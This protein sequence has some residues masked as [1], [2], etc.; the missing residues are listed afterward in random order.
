MIGKTIKTLVRMTIRAMSLCQ[1]ISPRKFSSESFLQNRL[2]P[3]DMRMFSSEKQKL[4]P[5]SKYLTDTQLVFSVFETDQFL[6]PYFKYDL[7]SI[8]ASKEQKELIRQK[9]IVMLINKY[10][11]LGNISGITAVYIKEDKKEYL[12]INS[13]IRYSCVRHEIEKNLGIFTKINKCEEASENGRRKI[14]LYIGNINFYYNEFEKS[15]S[16]IMKHL[17]FKLA[18]PIYNGLERHKFDSVEDLGIDIYEAFDQ[19]CFKIISN[20]LQLSKLNSQEITKPL[21]DH[22]SKF[23]DMTSPLD[24]LEFIRNLLANGIEIFKGLSKCVEGTYED[25]RERDKAAIIERAYMRHKKMSKKTDKDI[26]FQKFKEIKCMPLPTQK[27]IESEILSLDEKNEAEYSRSIDFLKHTFNIPWDNEAPTIWDINYS[28][29]ILDSSHYGLV[30]TKQR[31]LEFI[32]K[33][34]RIDNKKGLIV[35]LVGPPGVGKTSIA[36]GIAK[37]LQRPEILITMAGQSDPQYIKGFK[38]VY[39]DSQ[40]GVFIKQ[41]EMAKVKNP[42]FIL[43]EIDKLGFD[44]LKGYAN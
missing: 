15:V 17:P 39:V 22:L 23:I 26:Y 31:I 42:V 29:K 6:F 28:K 36:R 32:S 20:Y 11:A 40:P 18:L 4:S 34:K 41:Y 27:L 43:D 13:C 25:L 5:A 8:I 3:Y 7:E 2:L 21:E 19:I 12:K 35:L 30:E 1:H 9:K 16:E 33:N 24:K 14:Q 38:R 10:K 44:R 37:C